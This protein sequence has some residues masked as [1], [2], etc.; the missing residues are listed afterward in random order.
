M[1][2]DRLPPIVSDRSTRLAAL[3]AGHGLTFL[4]VYSFFV[5]ELN[6]LG[7]P[8]FRA[9]IVIL[10][11]VM[12]AGVVCAYAALAIPEHRARG[13]RIGLELVSALILLAEWAVLAVSILAMS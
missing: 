9:L 1:S 12:I 11:A 5:D 7:E 8:R 4:Q 2:N 10:F 6:G 3:M 13:V